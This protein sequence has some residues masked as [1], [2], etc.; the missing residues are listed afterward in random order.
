MQAHTQEQTKVLT[1]GSMSSF[2]CVSMNLL[3]SL[4]SCFSLYDHTAAVSHSQTIYRHTA[5]ATDCTSWDTH[6]HAHT[7]LHPDVC[8]EVIQLLAGGYRLY[9]SGSC[10]STVISCIME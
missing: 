3:H 5:T 6:T 10:T 7:T 9:V 1:V 2:Y 8:F 4:C